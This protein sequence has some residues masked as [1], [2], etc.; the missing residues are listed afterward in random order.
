MNLKSSFVQPLN[1]DHSNLDVIYARLKSRKKDMKTVP[2]HDSQALYYANRD[3]WAQNNGEYIHGYMSALKY[4]I[5][6]L[7]AQ[8]PQH[9]YDDLYAKSQGWAG[10]FHYSKKNM[11]VEKVGGGW[12]RRT[13]I[14]TGH[15]P[16]GYPIFTHTIEV[17]PT[18]AEALTAS[19][20]VSS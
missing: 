4:E 18:L 20:S 10:R 14:L 13:N 6:W 19:Q 3:H 2:C 15:K 11:R 16:D 17:Y 5:E 7:E 12:Q 8:I 1:L 9:Y